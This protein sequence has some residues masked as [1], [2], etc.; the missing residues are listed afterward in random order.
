VSPHYGVRVAIDRQLRFQSI[1]VSHIYLDDVELIEG[2]DA[3]QITRPRWLGLS[4][5]QVS[6]TD[7]DHKGFLT[8]NL[9]RDG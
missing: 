2:L 4:S 9:R 7:S 3:I 8:D 1:L 5:H 6:N